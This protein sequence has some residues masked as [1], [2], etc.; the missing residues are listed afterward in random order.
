[1]RRSYLIITL[2]ILAL[3]ASLAWP[4]RSAPN[5]PLA[6]RHSEFIYQTEFTDIPAGTKRLDVWIPYPVSDTNQQIRDV[7]I[8]SP[9]KTTITKDKEYGNS[10]RYVGVDNPK[11][12]SAQISM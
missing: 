3:L 12:A 11:T 8:D 10:I 1:M 7:R 9:F 5:R 4:S 2:V 6:E